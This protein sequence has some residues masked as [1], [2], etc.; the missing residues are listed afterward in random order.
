MREVSGTEAESSF[1]GTVTLLGG[2]AVD[3]EL[4]DHQGPSETGGGGMTKLE[5]SHDKPAPC[6]RQGFQ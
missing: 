6:V 3:N 2:G 1:H 4:W 5:Q